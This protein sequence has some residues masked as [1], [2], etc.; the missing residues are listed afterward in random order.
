MGSNSVRQLV[1]VGCRVLG[2][3]GQGDL[4]WGHVS[5]RDPEGRGA[6]MKAAGLGFGEVTAEDTLLVNW[7]GAV[8]EGDGRLHSEWPIH[9]AILAA[10]PDIGAVVHS[11]PAAAVAFASLGAPLRPVSHEAT[12]FV[13]PELARF[14]RTGDLILTAELGAAVADALGDRNALLL[15]NHGIVATGPDVPTAVMTAILLERACRVQ[16]AAMS[17]GRLRHWSSDDEAIAKRSNCYGAEMLAGAWEHLVRSLP[18]T[19]RKDR[20]IRSTGR[21]AR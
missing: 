19:P 4:I 15:V 7:S 11:H 13:P 8:I 2:S 1:S 16:V 9:A 5:A 12:L 20:P 18:S 21:R 3:A 6:W 17:A 10:R 14:T